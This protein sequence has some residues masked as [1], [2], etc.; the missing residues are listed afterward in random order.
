[1][2]QFDRTRYVGKKFNRLFVIDIR[3]TADGKPRLVCRC[4]CGNLHEV[5]T[6]CIKG[7]TKS[8]GC[9]NREQ[10]R[11]PKSHGRLPRK[12]HAAWLAMKNRCGLKKETQWS[13]RFYAGKGIRVCEEW[14]DFT[15]FRD[16]ALANGWEEGLE[17]DRKES[18]KNYT[19]DNCRWV[20]HKENMRNVDQVVYLDAFGE[21]KIST[22][23]AEDPRCSVKVG[24]L[25]RRLVLGWPI[26]DAISIPIGGRGHSRYGSTP[27]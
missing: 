21:S 9:L 25:R 6:S 18:D 8:C 19:P 17:L 1:M 15:V 4:D 27:A 22:Q 3:R 5:S 14:L 24:T 23:W 20:T 7:S 12:L 2:P 10:I 16:W 11:K 13:Y 26:E